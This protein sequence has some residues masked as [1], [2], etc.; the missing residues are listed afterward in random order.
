[1]TISSFVYLSPEDPFHGEKWGPNVE[2]FKRRFDPATSD[3]EGPI[4][5]KNL[6]FTY[7]VVLRAIA[8]AAPLLEKEA[9]YTGVYMSYPF[10]NKGASPGNL[11]GNSLCFTYLVVLCATA[12]VASLLRSVHT[13]V[14]L[15][16]QYIDYFLPQSLQQHRISSLTEFNFHAT[17]Q[18]SDN[19]ISMQ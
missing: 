1:M 10:E 12:K 6:Y 4:R 7:L 8:K 13:S 3:G 19:A 15:R 16:C 18:C 9:F 14:A 11:T 5:L 17:P 2:E